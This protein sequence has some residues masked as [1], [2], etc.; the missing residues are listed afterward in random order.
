MPH[1]EQTLILEELIWKK[2][3]SLIGIIILI[4]AS[5]K[6][7]KDAYGEAASKIESAENSQGNTNTQA[8]LE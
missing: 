6:T 2:D 5:A 1:Y 4:A 7:G 8:Q 3:Q